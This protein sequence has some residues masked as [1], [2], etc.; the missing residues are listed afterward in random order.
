MEG[1][2]EVMERK[3]DV[4]GINITTDYWAIHKTKTILI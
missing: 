2:R 4:A 3:R 1:G